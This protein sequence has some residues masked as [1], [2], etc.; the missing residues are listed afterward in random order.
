MNENQFPKQNTN[1]G[2]P[3]NKDDQRRYV[4]QNN[5]D[6]EVMQLNGIWGTTEVS[7][8]FV[9]KLNSMFRAQT[10]T[11]KEKYEEGDLWSLLSFYTRDLR[12][13]NLNA[14][15]LSYCEYWLNLASDTLTEGFVEPFIM[16]LSRVA[17][18]IEL[19]QSKGGFLRK[20]QNTFTREDYIQTNEA[21]KKSLLGSN[22]MNNSNYQRP[23]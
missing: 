12:L 17:S 13:G 5:L 22:K 23:Y 15:E 10:G 1:I 21:G 14:Q 16:M 7:P 6:L 18:K 3:I 19:S 20:R 9:T 2:S 4:P 11:I 8:K